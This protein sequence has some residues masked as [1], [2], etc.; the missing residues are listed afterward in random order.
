MIETL[1]DLP[2][3]TSERITVSVCAPHGSVFVDGDF[4]HC[5]RFGPE[6][7]TPY[8]VYLDYARAIASR[9]A[10]PF[11]ITSTLWF[12]PDWYEKV[13]QGLEKVVQVA[14]RDSNGTRIVTKGYRAADGWHYFI[15]GKRVALRDTEFVLDCWAEQ[16]LHPFCKSD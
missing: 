1:E 7:M 6:K 15:S 12:L 14:L 16:Q 9:S 2:P 13:Y 8:E 11:R 3:F 5:C 10:Q 4:V